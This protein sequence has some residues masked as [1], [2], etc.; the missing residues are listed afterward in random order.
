MNLDSVG[1]NMWQKIRYGIIPNILPDFS[2][3]TLYRLDIN[4]RAASIL[5]LVSASG[6]GSILT[7]A[8]TMWSWELLGTIL[9]A[10]I[11]MVMSVDFVSSRLRAKLV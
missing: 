6:I 3:I 10:V 5:G 4:V 2:S 8:S 9:V 1:A 7:I 11:L